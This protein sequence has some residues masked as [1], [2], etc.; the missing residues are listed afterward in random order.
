[1]KKISIVMVGVLILALSL[2]SCDVMPFGK[3]KRAEPK[4]FDNVSLHEE[5]NLVQALSRIGSPRSFSKRDVFAPAAELNPVVV[6][7][8]PV[9]QASDVEI[10]FSKLTL[11][12]T[13][14]SDRPLAFIRDSQ[15]D[16]NFIV[17][18]GDRVSG[19]LVKE[20][21]RKEVVLEHQK[22]E[23]LLKISEDKP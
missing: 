14:L 21:K 8:D 9:V 16:Q 13:F 22:K 12:A 4:A 17:T 7:S 5:T 11:S 3:T 19:F 1:M 18:H 20:I 6:A 23:F 15:Q 2:S 10:D